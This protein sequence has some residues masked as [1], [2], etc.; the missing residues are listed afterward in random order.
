MSHFSTFLIYICNYFSLKNEKFGL[1]NDYITAK[2]GSPERCCKSRDQTIYFCLWYDIDV[3]TTG[4]LLKE[5][6]CKK[7][8]EM[9]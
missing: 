7:Y 3:R 2:I 4:S 8:R 9:T 5:L 1:K 6:G